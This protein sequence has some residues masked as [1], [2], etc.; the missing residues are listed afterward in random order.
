MARFKFKCKPSFIMSDHDMTGERVRVFSFF[1]I[2]SFR[3]GVGKAGADEQVSK[4]TCLISI[5]DSAVGVF[6]AMILRP[7]HI[8]KFI[9]EETA[10][11]KQ[12][13]EEQQTAT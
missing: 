10:A 8:P 9:N 2:L 12:L 4:D 7:L 1:R 6:H 13:H 11:K 5:L 3:S